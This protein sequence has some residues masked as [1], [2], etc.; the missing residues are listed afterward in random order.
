MIVSIE[1]TVIQSP[2]KSWWW[3]FTIWF[4]G[5][6]NR[7][8]FFFL[9]TLRQ[10]NLTLRTR[11]TTFVLRALQLPPIWYVMLMQ[12]CWAYLASNL[13]VLPPDGICSWLCSGATV[14]YSVWQPWPETSCLWGAQRSAGSINCFSLHIYLVFEYFR[15][16]SF[17]V[18]N[19]RH[20]WF[21]QV[22][23]RQTCGE[24]TADVW[25]G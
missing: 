23:V 20:H 6:R 7:W 13:L 8:V 14:F 11:D 24:E 22:A 1:K 15:K 4:V 19:R 5:R 3:S 16:T 17:T 2:R 12:D 10:I 21:I 9:P 25:V 18:F